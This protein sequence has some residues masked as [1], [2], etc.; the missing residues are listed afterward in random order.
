VISRTTAF[1]EP[2]QLV[3]NDAVLLMLI[4]S[5]GFGWVIGDAR[6]GGARAERMRPQSA[7][8]EHR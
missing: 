4:P 7:R 3:L 1:C 5:G 8:G 2:L 6:G